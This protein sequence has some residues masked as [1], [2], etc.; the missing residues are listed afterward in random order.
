MGS[1][2]YI[3]KENLSQHTTQMQLPRGCP[4][5]PLKRANVLLCLQT[6]LVPD[7]NAC[8]SMA[9]LDYCKEIS[10]KT[11]EILLGSPGALSPSLLSLWTYY[12]FLTLKPPRGIGREAWPINQQMKGPFALFLHNTFFSYTVLNVRFIKFPPKKKKKKK[13]S[14]RTSKLGRAK[15]S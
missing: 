10:R 14:L 2:F 4:T 7:G 3:K 9:Q 1:F 5:N 8:P 15:M 13:F 12:H 6:H 11:T